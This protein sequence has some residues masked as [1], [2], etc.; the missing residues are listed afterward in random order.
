LDAAFVYLAIGM[1]FIIGLIIGVVALFFFRRIVFNRQIRIAERKAVKMVAD[2]RNEAKSCYSRRRKK[3]SV[4]GR[5]RKTTTGNAKANCRNRK[6][7]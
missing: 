5:P 1:A 6:T 4:T 2:A 3:L 7:G